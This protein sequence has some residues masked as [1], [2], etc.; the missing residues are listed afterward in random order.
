VALVRAA[1]AQPN[2]IA[3]QFHDGRVMRMIA[4]TSK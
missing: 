2:A 1:D 3:Y 4:A